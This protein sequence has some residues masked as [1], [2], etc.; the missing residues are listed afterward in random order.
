LKKAKAIYKKRSGLIDMFNNHIEIDTEHLIVT[1]QNQKAG[2]EVAQEALLL[3][4]EKINV[5][6]E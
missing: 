3:F 2:V 5:A 1:G 6:Y 4:K